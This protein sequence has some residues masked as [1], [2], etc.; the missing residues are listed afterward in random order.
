M[1]GSPKKHE[2]K[3]AEIKARGLAAAEVANSLPV[4]VVPVVEGE[5]TTPS[6]ATELTRT[7]L[8]RAMR[9]K[10]QA[11]AD[12]AIAVLVEI[13]ESKTASVAEK[14]GA[15]NDLLAWGFGKPAQEVE[16]GDGAQVILIRRFGDDNAQ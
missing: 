14:R 4:P 6:D 11:H 2:R 8:K 12:K 3:L 10:A 9:A 1:A 15:S 5:L 7:A 16:A 13:I